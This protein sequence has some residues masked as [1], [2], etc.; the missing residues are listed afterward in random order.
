MFAISQRLASILQRDGLL[1]LAGTGAA[2]HSAPVSAPTESTKFVAPNLQ[3]QTL[4]A[5]APTPGRAQQQ[6]QRVFA[7]FGGESSYRGQ[8]SGARVEG[9]LL[10]SS[11]CNTCVLHGHP[12]TSQV[13]SALLVPGGLILLP[14]PSPEQTLVRFL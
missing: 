3:Q 14:I 6:V 13:A 10:L 1:W 9:D 4:G 11:I 8:G 12:G 7:V 2:E 5:V